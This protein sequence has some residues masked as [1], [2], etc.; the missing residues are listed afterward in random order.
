VL[1]RSSELGT[2]EG[3]QNARSLLDVI[4]GNR[5]R[6]LG[7]CEAAGCGVQGDRVV[8]SRTRRERHAG[9]DVVAAD[10]GRCC[11]TRTGVAHG[12]CVRTLEAGDDAGKGAE[13]RTVDLGL[14]AIG[15]HCKALS[16]DIGRRGSGAVHCVVARIRS[17]K[18]QADR[19]NR[20]AVTNVGIAE[21]REASD[22]GD[23]ICANNAF[24][25][26]RRQ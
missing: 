5:Q 16:R 25:R 23:N 26:S 18:A 10:K 19:R 9:H 2:R 20:F 22:V 3:V 14:G 24:P 11:R 6:S 4:G 21:G 7:H 17:G 12:Y 1:F 15:G 8:R 13:H